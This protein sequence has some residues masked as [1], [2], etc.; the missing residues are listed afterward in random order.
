M[1]IVID[2]KKFKVTPPKGNP[3]PKGKS[4][5]FTTDEPDKPCPDPAR[6]YIWLDGEWV[7]LE[8]DAEYLDK[9]DS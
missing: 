2:G 5:P 4:T 1:S 7:L 3:G 6:P 9:K 8:T